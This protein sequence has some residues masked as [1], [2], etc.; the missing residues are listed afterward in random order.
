MKKALEQD[1]KCVFYIRKNGN[2][3]SQDEDF[4]LLM[5]FDRCQ[6]IAKKQGY[7]AI[8]M[9]LDSQNDT[10]PLVRPGFNSLIN[11]L[12]ENCISAV[13]IASADRLTRSFH[14]YMKI[15]KLLEDKNIKLFCPDALISFISS[16]KN[17]N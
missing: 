17:K 9:F 12:R 5:Q 6:K 14:T 8:K 7:R 2:Y 3:S 16:I 11:Y 13:I 1:K 4:Y 10:N 15:E